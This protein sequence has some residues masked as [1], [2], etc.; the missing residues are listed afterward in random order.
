MIERL[1]LNPG[2]RQEEIHRLCV[3]EHIKRQLG[4]VVLSGLLSR[5]DSQFN[6]VLTT[7]FDDLLSD[8]LAYFRQTRLL[9]IAH[10]SLAP[11]IRSTGKHP[12]IIKLHGDHQL[13][14][15][16]TDT[17]TAA[18]D[19]RIAERVATVLHDRGLIVLGYGGNDESIIAMLERL[20]GVKP[21]DKALFEKVF[22]DIDESRTALG[23]RV[24]ADDKTD[25]REP[26]AVDWWLFDLAAQGVKVTDPEGAD[27][28]YRRGIETLPD[29]YELLG[30][31]AIFLWQ[32]RKQPD[33]A[34]EFYKRAIDADPKD[35][36]IIGNYAMLLLS[37][38]RKKEGLEKLN[39]ATAL[40]ASEPANDL[41]AELGFYWY[42][43]GPANERSKWLARL[44]KMLK[45]GIRSPG[46][47]LTPIVE[48]AATDRHP[49]KT[50]LGKLAAVIDDETKLDSLKNLRAW[51]NAK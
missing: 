38:G 45:D 25:I 11:F 21:P 31:Y 17:E 1:F 9:V 29:S 20:L 32:E 50:W 19:Q 39:E 7:N 43:Q 46:W 3:G 34:E 2:D 49:A 4:Y 42:A 6:I 14:P 22:R 12:L 36:N 15:R 27:A 8:A 30:N 10:D 41:S 33:Q 5:D 13:A 44:K 40:H 24:A 37:D 23:K 16:N 28:I 48:R 47:D 26:E 51:K 18:L 35:T